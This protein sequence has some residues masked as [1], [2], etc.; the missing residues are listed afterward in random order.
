M[1]PEKAS[2]FG[3]AIECKDT[4]YDIKA[5]VNDLVKLWDRDMRYVV[6]WHHAYHQ[7]KSRP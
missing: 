6:S 1:E 4:K 2:L 7:N 3:P 5:G